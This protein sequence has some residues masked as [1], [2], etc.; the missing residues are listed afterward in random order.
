MKPRVMATVP[1]RC[2]FV[3]THVMVVAGARC[4]Q[5]KYRL[6]I[7]VPL[8]NLSRLWWL[9]INLNNAPIFLALFIFCPQK[10]QECASVVL[11]LH[12]LW[13]SRTVKPA[14]ENQT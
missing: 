3:C 2:D 5:R 10:P 11:A 9:K 1:A 14:S 8:S 13:S 12:L 4:G 6:S 7:I